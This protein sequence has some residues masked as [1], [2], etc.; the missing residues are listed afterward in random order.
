VASLELME[1][2]YEQLQVIDK[3][4]S[5]IDYQLYDILAKAYFLNGDVAQSLTYTERYFNNHP[6]HTHPSIQTRFYDISFLLAAELMDTEKMAHA[7]K[8]LKKLLEH[9]TDEIAKMRYYDMEA[10]YFALIGNS[11]QALKSSKKYVYYNKLLH[12][13][14]PS[15]YNNLAT[16]FE[17]NQQL[18]SA[19]YYYKEGIALAQ[20]M[21][22]KEQNLLYG[23]LSHVYK[24]KGNYKEALQAIDS[25][26]T[27]LLRIKE[28]MN[29]NRLKE[30]EIQYQTKQK[31]IEISTLKENIEL[32]TKN[33][34]QQRWITF[35][36]ILLLLGF[37]SY[38]IVFYRQ[39]LLNEKNKRL[40]LQN[41]KLE[42]EQRLLQVQLNPH[43]IYN[44]IANLQG[45]INQENKEKANRYLIT[46]SKL[47][48]KILEIN[49]KELVNLKEDLDTIE[50][51]LQVQQ[52]RYPN[53]F[54][55]R[56]QTDKVAVEELLIPPMLV[57]PFIENAIE[58]GFRNTTYTGQLTLQVTQTETELVL[59]ITDNGQGIQPQPKEEQKNEQKNEQ[60]Q[61]L[62]Q[63]ITQERLD[64]LFT[65][66]GKRAYFTVTN[67]Q[68]THSTS[69][70]EV[71]LCLP[72]IYEY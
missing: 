27:H 43:F 28:K 63:I 59:R 30:L 36:S 14:S 44:A 34:K 61:S 15:V 31:D 53:R 22:I 51:Y 68:H 67:L 23:G 25:S 1:L 48:R 24:K 58:H 21:N 4:P 56:I 46:L 38:G 26:F 5:S 19:I 10:R 35:I 2:L 32:Q 7:L 45:F 37:L 69:G 33:A 11:E 18:D 42:L 3:E 54:D 60:K 41:K 39:R 70:V 50:N 29:D 9:S 49:R 40:L 64:A 57:Q 6:F 8:N 13:L 72:L 52:M 20:Q 12:Q 17:R 62:S 55:Y 16:S 65:T 66:N 47:I 71:T